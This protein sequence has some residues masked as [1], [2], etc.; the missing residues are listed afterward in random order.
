MELVS[1]FIKESTIASKELQA[2]PASVKVSGHES[3]VI[4]RL[5]R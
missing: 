1:L 4:K 3:T 5:T 2:S